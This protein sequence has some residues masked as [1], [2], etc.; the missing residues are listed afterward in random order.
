MVEI[1]EIKDDDALIGHLRACG[2][3]NPGDFLDQTAENMQLLLQERCG[4]H[5][6]LTT[7]GKWRAACQ[8]ALEDLPWMRNWVHRS[9]AGSGAS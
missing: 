2:V 4:V 5:I 8:K 6:S 7:L 1:F 9:V 3:S